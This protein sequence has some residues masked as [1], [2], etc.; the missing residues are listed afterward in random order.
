[1]HN[2]L[3]YKILIKASQ[4]VYNYVTERFNLGRRLRQPTCTCMCIS[5][6][7]EIVNIRGV[8][9]EIRMMC[10]AKTLSRSLRWSNCI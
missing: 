3:G 6:K 2:R 9:T 5:D 1:M 4:R 8:E 10:V 7:I